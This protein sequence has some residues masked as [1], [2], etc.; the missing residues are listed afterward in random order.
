MLEEFPFFLP[1]TFFEISF[2]VKYFK[3]GKLNKDYLLFST[4]KYLD[5]EEFAKVYFG[6]NERGLYFFFEVEKVIEKV[7]YPDF[8]KGDSIELFIDTRNIKNYG[9]TTKFCHHFVI[10]PKKREGYHVKEITRFREEDMHRIANPLDF[11]VKVEESKKKYF[12]DLFIP[13]KC[14]YGYDTS[15]FDKLGFTYRINRTSKDPQHFSESSRE[16]VIERQP[17]LFATALLKK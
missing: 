13:S 8:R 5:E 10:F 12:L 2:D 3:K 11:Q 6:W 14:L 1:L 16:Y 17:A 15:K 4:S 7:C 9:Y